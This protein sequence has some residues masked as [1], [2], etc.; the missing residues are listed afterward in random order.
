VAAIVIASLSNTVVKTGMVAA[1]G[2]RGL[3]RLIIVSGAL[4]LATGASVLLATGAV[5]LN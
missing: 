4:I 5:T 3:R 1:L 2:G